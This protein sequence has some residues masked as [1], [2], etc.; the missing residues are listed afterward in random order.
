MSLFLYSNV[1]VADLHKARNAKRNRMNTKHK[2]ALLRETLPCGW[3]VN[4]TSG[5]RDV[6]QPHLSPQH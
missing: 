1:T 2:I 3:L 5:L 4:T 6:K